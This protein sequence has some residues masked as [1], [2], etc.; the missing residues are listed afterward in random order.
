MKTSVI[1]SDL[2]IPFSTTSNTK[3]DASC[4]NVLLEMLDRRLSP[5][6]SLTEERLDE[7]GIPNFPDV[8]F[9]VELLSC[10]RVSLVGLSNPL[11][12]SEW[13]YPFVV[14]F[15]SSLRVF[16]L[17]KRFF[18]VPKI[19]VFFRSRPRSARLPVIG[20]VD[21]SLSCWI[22]LI[23]TFK[24]LLFGFMGVDVTGPLADKVGDV[25]MLLS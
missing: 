17:D 12:A 1:K 21:D 3:L 11:A 15:V 13:L 2:L 14:P 16:D 8:D 25:L 4:K 18:N 9:K 5:L 24:V 6:I 20:S 10:V 19:E 23:F 7:P 22:M